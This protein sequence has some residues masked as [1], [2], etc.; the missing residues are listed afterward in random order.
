MSQ[1][2]KPDGKQRERGPVMGVDGQSGAEH[3]CLCDKRERPEPAAW[4]GQGPPRVRR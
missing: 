2:S 1:P 4:I 3:V